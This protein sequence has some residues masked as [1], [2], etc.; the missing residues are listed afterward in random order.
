MIHL[1]TDCPRTVS[2]A[3]LLAVR[4]THGEIAYTGDEFRISQVSRCFAI[5]FL[6]LFTHLKL[7]TR[8]SGGSQGRYFSRTIGNTPHV[9]QASRLARLRG[10]IVPRR[11]DFRLFITVHEAR[12]AR[13]FAVPGNR[14]GKN[15]LC[16]Q[17]RYVRRVGD[18]HV[19]RAWVWNLFTGTARDR[20]C[21]SVAQVAVIRE[22]LDFV[23]AVTSTHGVFHSCVRDC[24][25]RAHE[26]SLI[27]GRIQ[28][29]WF[30]IAPRC[31]LPV[32]RNREWNFIGTWAKVHHVA[33]FS[34]LTWLMA[35]TKKKK[36]INKYTS[37]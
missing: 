14:V 6:I 20:C 31:L 27:G 8:R 17:R 15:E 3:R 25:H 34:R 11:R 1:E 7:A 21:N 26:N 28:R 35:K 2:F 37:K 10:T 33:Q 36:K 4:T 29:T 32:A 19:T 12:T 5:I 13:V 22:D 18:N 16:A 24:G 23:T 30:F 9:Y